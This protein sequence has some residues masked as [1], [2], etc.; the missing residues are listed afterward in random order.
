[1]NGLSATTMAS[2]PT[3]PGSAG[4]SRSGASTVTDQPGSATPIAPSVT[5]TA[6]E[7]SCGKPIGM[8]TS[9]CP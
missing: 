3:S 4:S 7:E 8:P 9:V 5:G 1:M 2:L 6:T